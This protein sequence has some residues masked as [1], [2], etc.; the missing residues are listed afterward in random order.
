VP[1]NEPHF[2]F[3]LKFYTPDPV[4]LEDE[5][6]RSA[7]SAVIF[8][9]LTVLKVLQVSLVPPAKSS[10]TRPFTPSIT[11]FQVDLPVPCFLSIFLGESLW[12]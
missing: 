8:V 11:V 6:T 2:R 4:L 5:F 7:L 9:L 10:D 3:L 12:R 1:T